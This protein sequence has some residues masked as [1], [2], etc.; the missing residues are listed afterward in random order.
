MER[1]QNSKEYLGIHCESGCIGGENEEYRLGL[2]AQCNKIHGLA[3]QDFCQNMFSQKLVRSRLVGQATY[4][5]GTAQ[6]IPELTCACM[7]L[8]HMQYEIDLARCARPELRKRNF[9]CILSPGLAVGEP[10]KHCEHCW[11]HQAGQ[12]DVQNAQGVGL[13]AAHQ[14]K[15]PLG[16]R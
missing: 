14:Q 9:T 8:T 16:A 6:Q 15:W 7:L 13:S 10:H 4:A 2:N 5:T 3:C 1:I 12:L 11:L